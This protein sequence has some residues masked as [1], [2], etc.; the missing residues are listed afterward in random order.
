VRRHDLAYT[1]TNKSG[2]PRRV[3]LPLHYVAN[4]RLSGD[5]TLEY[6]SSATQPIAALAV[7]ERSTRAAHVVV[8]EGLSQKHDA[9][10]LTSRDLARLSSAP[11]IPNGERAILLAAGR[12]LTRAEDL[13]TRL[14]NLR[15]WIRAA[16][17]WVST[18]RSD[19]SALGAR[20]GDDAKRL[21]TRLLTAEERLRRLIDRAGQ[22]EG[23]LA[24]V[25]SA[26]LRAIATLPAD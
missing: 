2:S 14:S 9:K 21:V 5:A 7:T 22:L 16:N 3:Y 24:G 23:E 15:S 12:D 17:R 20:E 6:D 13:G 10:G 8:E 19:L 25:Q 4:A 18:A 26:A 1:L 11:G